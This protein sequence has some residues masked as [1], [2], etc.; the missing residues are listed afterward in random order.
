MKEDEN[1]KNNQN[2]FDLYN[3]IGNNINYNLNTQL[4]NFNNIYVNN[5]NINNF[6]QKNIFDD[7]QIDKNN[8]INTQNF[9]Q[10]AINKSN[11]NEK[12]FLN[13][14][15]NKIENF[16]NKKNNQKLK[17]QISIQDLN[18]INLII[19][20]IP[21]QKKENNYHYLQMKILH[22][23]IYANEILYPYLYPYMITLLND[24]FGNYIYQSFIEILNTKNLYNF[25]YVLKNNFKEISCSKNGTRVIQKLIEK[26]TNIKQGNN[27]IQ[28]SLIEMLKGKIFEL[29]NDENANHIIQKFIIN[30]QY[31]YNNFIYEELY[32]NFIYIAITKYGCCVIQKCL[33]NGNKEQKEKIVC[34]ILE[35]TFSLITNQFGNYVYQCIILLKDEKINYKIFEIIYNKIIPLCKEKYSSNVIEKILDINNPILVNQLI[36]HITKN[37]NKIIELLTNKYG[38]YIIQKIL[39]I[40]T[41]KNLIYRIL[42]IIAKNIIIINNVPFGK[43]LINKLIDKYPILK[44]LIK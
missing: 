12:I 37:D 33:I 38:N 39:N 24:Q 11:E 25:L 40:S 4:M 27:I 29:S 32:E 16:Q 26:S 18:I 41:E 5:K 19:N 30:I 6:N 23:P 15:M 14:F 21:S 7:Q 31:P 22:N 3:N 13:N 1:G 36:K 43:Q 10:I 8:V 42:N 35:N 28:K 9:F 17:S 2:D 34:L 44:D 20:D